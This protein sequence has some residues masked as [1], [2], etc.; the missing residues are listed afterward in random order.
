ML[1]WLRRATCQIVKF[2]I[3]QDAV[4]AVKR[5]TA[6]WKI[7]VENFLAGVCEDSGDLL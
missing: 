7:T 5:T 4:A 1:T 3:S 6:R 2:V